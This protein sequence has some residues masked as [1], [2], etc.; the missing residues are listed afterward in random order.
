MINLYTNYKATV[1]QDKNYVSRQQSII[2]LDTVL[3][4]D[5][6]KNNSNKDNNTGKPN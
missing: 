3:A 1:E 2:A 4:N 5:R 6:A